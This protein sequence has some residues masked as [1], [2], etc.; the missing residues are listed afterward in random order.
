MQETRFGRKTTT[1]PALTQSPMLEGIVCGY[2]EHNY[3]G[4]RDLEW[5]FFFGKFFGSL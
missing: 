5:L 3:Y 4:F 2:L 1:V